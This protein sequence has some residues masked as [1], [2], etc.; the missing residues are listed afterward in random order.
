MALALQRSLFYNFV[1]SMFDEGI[2]ND[3]F[4]QLLAMKD[5]IRQD[6]VVRAITSYCIYAQNLFSYLTYHIQPEVDY[7]QVDA[8]ACDFFLRTSSI[9]A[10]HVKLSCAELIQ[11]CQ[12]NDK[13]Y[14]SCALYWTK[15]E[16]SK[17]R[18]KFETLLQCRWKERLLTLK[19]VIERKL[20]AVIFFS[21]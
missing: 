21:D 6:Y 4:F 2:V 14:C 1:Q 17:L 8:S 7:H 5:A 9:G 11:A 19:M 3:E 12:E 16:Y 13:E 18:R 15:N 20:E 10:E